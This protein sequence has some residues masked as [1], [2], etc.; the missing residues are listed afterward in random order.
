MDNIASNL[1]NYDVVIKKRGEQKAQATRHQA[2]ALSLSDALG[3]RKSIGIYM[4]VCKKYPEFTIVSVRDYVLSKV[5]IR[6][7]GRYFMTVLKERTK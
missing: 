5:G 1:K 2:L 6:N 7:R 4:R 3:D